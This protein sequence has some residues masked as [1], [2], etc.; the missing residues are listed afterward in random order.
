MSTYDEQIATGSD[1]GSTYTPSN[2]WD[3]TSGYLPVGNSY[4]GF[5]RFTNIPI[6]QGSTIDSAYLKVYT[7]EFGLSNAVNIRIRATDE[8]DASAFPSSSG[9]NTDPVNR[10][11]TSASVTGSIPSTRNYLWTSPDIK[12][13]I[14]EV[15]D[16]GGWE[17]GNAMAIAIENNGSSFANELNA[18][19]YNTSKAA[20]LIINYTGT[21]TYQKQVIVTAKI[22]NPERDVGIKVMKPTYD[23]KTDDDPTH[24]IFNSDYDS[25]K[26]FTSGSVTVTLLADDVADSEAVTH[27]LGYLPYAE[28]YAKLDDDSEWFACPFDGFGATVTYGATFRVTDTEI[29]FYVSSSGFFDNHD[30]H[31]RYFLFRNDLDI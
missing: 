31:F 30:F 4:V 1:D 10:P 18:Y 16:R 11:R 6:G 26:Y 20:E 15:V 5:F 17:D 25:L 29:T 27:N 7:H 23:V 24:Q 13:V 14:Q 28:V 22:I 9:T 3:V 2:Y 19:E 12:S 8:D 21:S